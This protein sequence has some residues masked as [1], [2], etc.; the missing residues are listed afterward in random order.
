MKIIEKVNSLFGVDLKASIHPNPKLKGVESTI[1]FEHTSNIAIDPEDVIA[2]LVTQ[3]NANGTLYLENVARQYMRVLGAIPAKLQIPLSFD[4]RSVFTCHTPD[5]LNAYWDIFRAASNYKQVNSSTSGMFSAGMGCYMRYLQHLSDASWH[6]VS[7]QKPRDSEEAQP[8][9]TKAK[10][11]TNSVQQV[12][13]TRPELCAQTC[14]LTCTIK[15]Q[16]VSLDKSNWSHL[17]V[18]ITEWFIADDNPNLKSLNNKPLRG[19]KIFFSP[20][21]ANRGRSV[22]LSNGKWVYTNYDPVVAVTVIKKL[23]LHCGLDINNVVITYE[24]KCGK[25]MQSMGTHIN[26]ANVIM[27]APP[28]PVFNSR[29]VEQLT[30]VLSSHFANGFR[31]KSPIEM[32]RFR[33]FAAEDLD[34]ELR[35]SDEEL[36]SYIMV[37]GTTFK[38]KVYAVS[39]QAKERI[40]KLVEDYFAKGAQAIFFSEFY[41]KNENWLFESSVVSE[42]MLINILRRLFPQLSFTQTCFGYTDASVFSVLESEILR[43]WG[44]EVLLSYGQL[45]ERLRYI[46]LERIK[47]ALGQNGDFIWSFVETFS[48]VSRIDITNEERESI[49]EAAVRECN[50]RGYASISDLPFGEI[51]ERNHELSIT[52]V[53]TAVYRI[54]LSDKFDKRGKIVFRKGDTIDAL[55]IMK[56]YC[57]SIDKCL[58]DDLLAYEEELT[59]EVHRWIPMEAGNAVLVRID[60]DAYVAEKYVHFNVDVIDEAIGLF[61]KGDYLPLKSFTALGAFPNCGQTWNLF[62]LESYSRRFS[63]SFRFD[64]PSF[65]SRNAGAVIRKSCNMDYTEIMADAVANA[66]VTLKDTAVGKFLYENGYRGKSTTAKVSEIIDKAKAIRQRV[67]DV[68]VYI[69]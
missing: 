50:V 14:P 10:G 8:V 54:C 37:C 11:T 47:N 30:D 36:K 28:K 43:V 44:D 56:K 66:N 16:A 20:T 7:W 17:L 2:W 52:A 24:P 18:A 60:K 13:F 22:L 59:G 35:L 29:V 51:M 48:H 15:G 38:D 1:E 68:L 6:K 40:K 23:C 67:E 19:S 55:T 45:A 69:R 62:L 12:D 26:S 46:P 58:L 39:T 4:V 34:E 57:Q 33:L 5:E 41:A 63:R 65:N 3:L 9:Y 31:I 49:R 25:P 64:T 53:H 21:K 61:V 32:A 42:D 27:V